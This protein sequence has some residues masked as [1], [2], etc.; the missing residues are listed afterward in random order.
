MSRIRLVRFFDRF[1]HRGSGSIVESS[2]GTL[3]DRCDFVY[4]S[5]SRHADLIDH[6]DVHRGSDVG[7]L[8][9]ALHARARAERPAR[10]CNCP[11]WGLC[12][13][14]VSTD[15]PDEGDPVGSPFLLRRRPP[16]LSE[17]EVMLSLKKL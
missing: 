11:H 6:R 8:E 15:E 13:L 9:R 17:P 4:G 2:F 3:A 14:V 16:N 1:S 7:R 5:L 10:P 12:A